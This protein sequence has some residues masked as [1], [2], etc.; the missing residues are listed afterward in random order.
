MEYTTHTEE[1]VAPESLQTVKKSDSRTC[2]IE[3]KNPAAL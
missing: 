3:V 2:T 1:D